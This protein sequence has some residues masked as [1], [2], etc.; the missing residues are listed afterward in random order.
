MWNIMTSFYQKLL[1]T[2]ILLIAFTGRIVVYAMPLPQLAK[3]MI[4]EQASENNEKSESSD[5][6]NQVEEKFKLTDLFLNSA[7]NFD[8]IYNHAFKNDLYSG[9]FILTYCYLQVP[10]QPPK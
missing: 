8:W 3:E 7:A 5:K 4:K 10:E 1:I 9:N 2:L 6:Q